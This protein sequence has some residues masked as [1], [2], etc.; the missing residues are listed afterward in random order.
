M[1][2]IAL[3]GGIASGKS[4][5]A[6]HLRELGAVI[7]DADHFARMAVGAGMPALAAIRAHFGD[8][9]IRPDGSLDRPALA[10]IVFADEEQRAVLNGITH[11]EIARLTLAA[12]AEVRSGDPNA[13]IVHDIPLLLEARH[14]YDYDEIWVADAPAEV[15]L[16]RL[17]DERGLDRAEAARRV[18]SQATDEQ[19]RRIAD[20]LFDTTET[21]DETLAHVEREWARVSAAALTDTDERYGA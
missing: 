16:E 20:V 6:N 13:I 5:I 19:R 11:P 7:L 1:T 8:R 18:G 4:T 12:K 10:A 17:V 15:R 2:T 21:L 14:N 9:V 3:T